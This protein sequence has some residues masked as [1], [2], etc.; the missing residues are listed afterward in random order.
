MT[1]RRLG[2]TVIFV[3]DWPA[4]KDWYQQVLGLES[5]ESDDRGRWAAFGFP[6]GDAELALHGGDFFSV[7][8]A[9]ADNPI[10]VSMEVGDIGAAVADLK[11]NRVELVKDVHEG[12]G[13]V[14]LADFKD[15]EGNLLQ[16]YQRLGAS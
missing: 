7:S 14:L 12:G 5:K 6:E 11:E 9:S 13:G 2:Y 4:M 3:R 16:F 10:V 1:I 8:V 15:P